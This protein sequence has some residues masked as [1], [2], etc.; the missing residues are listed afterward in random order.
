MAK[1]AW[2]VEGEDSSVLSTK[3]ST[4]EIIQ[5]SKVIPNTREKSSSRRLIPCLGH[6]HKHADTSK[7]KKVGHGDV[8][9]TLVISIFFR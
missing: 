2:I 3:I 6:I 1:G 5:W 9:D 8:K 7:L 4:S